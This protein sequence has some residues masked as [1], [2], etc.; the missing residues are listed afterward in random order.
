MAEDQG[1]KKPQVTFP[2]KP[3]G[4]TKVWKVVEAAVKGR[5]GPP[6]K[7]TIQEVPEDRYEEVIEHMCTYFIADEPMCKCWNGVKDPDYVQFFRNLWIETLKQGLT[8]GA[9]V[10]DQNGGKPILAGVNVIMLSLQG[11]DFDRESIG[12]S[13]RAQQLMTV[14]EELLKKANIYEKYG[15][16]R[17]MGAIGLSVHPSYRGA[18]LGGHILNVRNDIGREYNI[19]VTATAFTS[20]ISQ[21][22]AARCGFEDVVAKDYDDM[23]DEEGNKVFPG[24]EAKELKIMAKRLY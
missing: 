9:F 19:E 18:S 4:Q 13:K 2:L 20:P 12:K 5:P 8:V 11:D 22:L 23:L 24:I 1:K 16:D 7:F 6:V 10:E 17:Y 14:L 15:V 3:P 21:K